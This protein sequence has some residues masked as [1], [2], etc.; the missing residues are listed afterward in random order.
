MN[1]IL[2]EKAFIGALFIDP[3][4]YEA[5]GYKIEEHILQDPQVKKIYQ[6]FIIQKNLDKNVSSLLIAEELSENIEQ[7]ME[8]LGFIEECKAVCE[9]S[10]KIES[11]A[12]RIIDTHSRQRLLCLSQ[13]ITKKTTSNSP[14]T[15]IQTHAMTEIQELLA[16]Q[17]RNNPVSFEESLSSWYT[18]Y[19]DVI[20]DLQSGKSRM[21]Y[22]IDHLDEMTHGIKKGKFVVFGA[23]PGVGKTVLALQI[24]I[25]IAKQK[26]RVLFFSLEM[27]NDEMVNRV[28]SNLTGI[29]YSKY[30]SYTLTD[31]ELSRSTTAHEE[32]KEYLFFLFRS[33]VT[34]ED[35]RLELLKSKK[36]QYDVLFVDYMQKMTSGKKDRYEQVTD[37]S[38]GLKG[39]TL[40]F[41]V[42]LI[43]TAQLNRNSVSKK[44]EEKPEIHHLKESGQIDQDADVIVL[45]F[46]PK[47]EEICAEGKCVY[48]LPRKIRGGRLD[49]NCDIE[50]MADYSKMRIYNKAS[51]S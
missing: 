28:C 12:N 35:I 5:V 29:P 14:I 38:Q 40:D 27:G 17:E 9:S 20:D 30:E 22:G 10:S 46:R 25:N 19:C 45:L 36:N 1:S 48:L 39:L 11:Y 3:E 13:E 43:A 24:A 33:Q 41:P 6:K 49:A 42:C 32:I 34:V 4:L 50:L 8:L 37:I 31:D 23:R 47:S 2:I 16:K 21:F 18:S 51:F 7:Q 44:E 26:K 15:E